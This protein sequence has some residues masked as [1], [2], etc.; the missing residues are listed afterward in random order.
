MNFV[1]IVD[2]VGI[3]LGVRPR[4]ID[5]NEVIPMVALIWYVL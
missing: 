5:S 1:L 4:W 2:L 3:V